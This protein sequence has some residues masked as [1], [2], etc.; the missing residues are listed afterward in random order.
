MLEGKKVRLRLLEEKDLLQIVEWRNKNYN[1]FY[2]F[3]L[4]ESGQQTWYRENYIGSNDVLF[5]IERVD[6]EEKLAK[7]NVGMVGLRNIDLRNGN[8]EFGRFVVEEKQRKKGY[9][10]EAIKLVLEY[11][12]KHLRLN[13]LYLD[14][15]DSNKEAIELYKK[16]GFEVEGVKKEHVF[17]DGKYRHLTCMSLLEM[18]WRANVEI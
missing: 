2:E 10:E 6:E 14:T 11:A 8:A 9:G 18:N 16:I 5:I 7:L 17:K 1:H 12:F 13:R 15:L 4:A 3:P